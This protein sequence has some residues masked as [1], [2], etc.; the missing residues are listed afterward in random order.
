MPP[1]P[2]RLT[3]KPASVSVP[4]P[5]DSSQEVSL[6]EGAEQEGKA[7]ALDTETTGLDLRHG[8]RPFLVTVCEPDGRQHVWRWPVDPLTRRVGYSRSDVL[9]IRDI[10]D[11]APRLALQNAKFDAA[12]LATV[13]L[14]EGGWQ[15]PW[16]KTHDTTLAGHLLKSNTPHN[17]TDMAVQYLGI[18]IERYEKATEDAVKSARTY[19]RF[20]L[21]D[22]M[23][24]KDGVDGMPSAKQTVWKY[25]LWLPRVVAEHCW[26]E[27][28]ARSVYQ[29]LLTDPKTR[30]SASA[31]ASQ[32]DVEG[33]EYR[34][35]EVDAKNHH[36]W[37]TVLE[38]YAN[39]DSAIT[40]ALWQV[41]CRLL[42][43]R[44]LWRLYQERRKVLPI[45]YEMESGGVAIS[46][47]RL[48][49]LEEK[50]SAESVKLEQECVAIAANYRGPC[51]EVGCAGDGFEPPA[52]C[53]VCK[54]S[55][56]AP[57]KLTMPRAGSN[58]SLQNLVFGPMA[59]PTVRRSK[60]TG[61]PTLDKAALDIYKDVLPADSLQLA[62]VTA[63]AKKR[64]FDTALTY[65]SSYRRFWRWMHSP[66]PTCI[67]E[68][69]TCGAPCPTDVCNRCGADQPLFPWYTL[70][71]SLNPTG[72]DTLRWSS[73][74]PNEQN[75]SKQ[76][77]LN[78]RY[79][80]GP[81]PGYEWWSMDA[82]NI[83]L[84]LPAYESGE[85]EM[86][87]LFE[88]ENDPPYFGS[89]HL[90]VSHILHP[91]EFEECVNDKGQLDG[92]IF[93]KK[94]A[95]TLYQWVKNGNF[96]VCVPMDTLALTKEGWKTYAEIE[97]GDMVL[98]LNGDILEWT[99]VR[100]KV[101]YEDAP[102]M[103][104]S[105]NHFK[106]V[107]TPNHRW[108]S[109][110]RVRSWKKGSRGVQQGSTQLFTTS[111]TVVREDSLVISAPVA[112]E[113]RLPV[114]D[115]EAALIG[116]V[117]GD[118]SVHKS[119]K[120]HG[121]ARGRDGSKVGFSVSFAQSKPAGVK[122]IEALL[123]RLGIKYRK[124]LRRNNGGRSTIFVWKLDPAEMRSLWQ[125]AGLWEEQDF[126]R[127]VLALGSQHRRAFLEGVWQAE[128]HLIGGHRLYTQNKGSYAEGIRLA[129]FMTGHNCT[130]YDKSDKCIE[131]R[132]AKATVTGQRM[133]KLY[134]P[135]AAV[136][137][138]KT[139]LDTWVMRQG[140][141]IMLTGNTYGATAESGTAD[142]A[143]HVK[144]GQRRV[145][146][147]FSRIKEL[148]EK[149]IA[150]ARKHGY[151][152][153]MPDK[154]V[155][156]S[157]G[158]PLWCTRMDNGD[159]LPTVPLNY[160]V[161]G[162][163]AGESRVLT[164][165]GLV[166]IRDLVGKT[167]NVWTGFGWAPAVGLN[168]GPCRR[169][170]VT[171][172]SGLV[173]RCDTR[174]KLKNEQNR[175]VPFE[176]LRP[177][178]YVALPVEVPPLEPSPL[179]NQWFLLGF[180][181]GDGCLNERRRELGFWVGR[182]KRPLLD[183]I[184]VL[185]NGMGYPSGVWRG[186]RRGVQLA[187]GTRDE[188]YGLRLDNNDFAGWLESV[189][190]D[191]SWRHDTKRVPD[192]V[193]TA[194]PQ[195]WRD[196][197][198]GLWLSDGCRAATS[199]SGRG[200]NMNNVPL[201]KEVQVLASAAGYDPHFDP[202]GH[203]LRFRWRAFNAKST[204][205][206]PPAALLRQVDSVQFRN[207]DRACD[208]I[209]DRRNFLAARKGGLVSQYVAERILSLNAA[210]PEAYRYD[211]VAAVKVLDRVENTYTMSVDHP[212][213]QFVADGVVHPN[214]AM[215]WTMKAMIR[216][217]AQLLEWRRTGFDGRLVM[218]VHDEI[219]FQFPKG[220]AHP[221]EDVYQDGPRKGKDKLI[222][223][224]NLWRARVLQNIMAQG[225]DDIGV[226]TPV[227]VEYH[228]HNWAE[229]ITF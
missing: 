226:P 84:R 71:P 91:K 10:I 57:Y 127:F 142:R 22:W 75:I 32:A 18:D 126:E 214:T 105:N 39:T 101:R 188:K 59:L 203:S 179:A 56:E 27:S 210:P 216:T 16:H 108:V 154:T 158:Y 23:I 35:P 122:Y 5:T 48:T 36:P 26:H 24:A 69:G 3:R 70:Y 144:G 212:L 174:H 47:A 90:L 223:R 163:L 180:L 104:I 143:Y 189:G 13:G 155:D 120:P 135:S 176:Q 49:E 167:V 125:R 197:M 82:K 170:N 141:R 21:T 45:V 65:M 159:I 184:E 33:W 94:Y 130:S 81:P 137:C 61:Q 44:G 162:C 146:E 157:R 46:G 102:L 64:K 217:H 200:L 38:D 205:K 177:G 103:Q 181:I 30:G 28:T 117:Y 29:S 156:P 83:E 153:T 202:S 132:E 166:P 123:A 224:S 121:P 99:P 100:H 6:G 221:R 31:R 138:I 1:L 97:V 55:G 62:F 89:N 136:W 19:C 172:S 204:R 73:S 37:H 115:D 66:D 12:A 227:G 98:G 15:W 206:Y 4:T 190:V 211:T 43:R 80:F 173:V 168:R 228:E 152:E 185:L 160:H 11:A 116:F 92:R 182:K 76:E 194:G 213:H 78:L 93:K 112:D 147:R 77:G 219:V 41:M 85:Q 128:G 95:S 131:M 50:F 186:V 164:D 106:A 134:L 86:I 196:F 60:K 145:E 191:L 110:R 201:L 63:L 229:G 195:A 193:W 7:V 222:R 148:N 111:D 149:C 133:C 187:A 124:A 220:N 14:E 52:T 40:M 67:P 17:L 139:D 51:A 218:Q 54:G 199:G 88:R 42:H 58:Q 225:G 96:A 107:T 175:W 79:A 161:Q 165:Q 114:T 169:A 118:G 171:L 150:F 151:V 9:E 53:P 192:A 183:A 215:W 8:A 113:C 68:C 208:H 129:I 178:G 2:K 74:N 109:R 34:P 140:D 198:E 207:Y 87:A 72:T 209:T 20:N 25:D 119:T